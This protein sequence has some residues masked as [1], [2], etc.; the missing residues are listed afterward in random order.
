MS[1]PKII[2]TLFAV[3]WLFHIEQTA[4]QTSPFASKAPAIQWDELN[5]RAIGFVK[6]YLEIHE[7]RLLK[8][9]EWGTP[10]FRLI[11]SIL[12]RYG[13]PSSL[14][15]LA[16]IESDL[17]S[18]AISSAGAVGPWQL[19]P[20][21]ARELGLTVTPALDE[22]TDLS[23]STHAAAK[24]LNDLYKNLNDWLLVVA[25]YNGGPAR[26]DNVIARK[27]SRDFWT[28]QNDLP[29]ESRNHVKK[30]IATHY[31][32][33]RNGSETTGMKPKAS[34]NLSKEELVMTDTIVINGKYIDLIIAKY[35][36]MDIIQFAKWNPQFN[37]KVSLDNYPLRIPKDKIEIFL[38][39]KNKIS[40][41][42]LML[43]MQGGLIN[44]SGFPDPVIMP[45]PP[46]KPMKKGNN[47]KSS[48]SS[49]PPPSSK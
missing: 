25:A 12:K 48:S 11:E 47:Q 41:E 29:T 1:Y 22:R 14:K 24:Y 43:I 44:E 49:K 19:M 42:S 8:M 17:K 39:Q 9:K 5:P 36:A 23:K 38:K 35:L 30:F 18:N 45:E 27:R 6:D 10:Y 37:E 20:Q 46:A 40:Q 2:W 16:V 33:E 28:I 31:I 26:V 15:Y 34:S 21:T 4:A 13:L 7:E 32:F 3:F